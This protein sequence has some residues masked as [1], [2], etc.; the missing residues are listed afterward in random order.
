MCKVDYPPFFCKTFVPFFR[1]LSVPEMLVQ[2]ETAMKDTGVK[3]EGL[4]YL[5]LVESRW[6]LWGNL[7]GL[8]KDPP[9]IPFRHCACQRIWTLIVIFTARALKCAKWHGLGFGSK[10]WT[11]ETGNPLAAVSPYF[12]PGESTTGNGESR[13][14][15]CSFAAPQ[16]RG[17]RKMTL[18][19]A[20]HV[21]LSIWVFPKIGV[22]PNHPF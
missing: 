3:R 13:L 14:C 21:G 18:Q 15:G 4:K 20:V 8:G 19:E 16:G 11:D 2:F 17:S 5:Q 7:L 22:S 12:G 1:A 9:F 6:H 10:W